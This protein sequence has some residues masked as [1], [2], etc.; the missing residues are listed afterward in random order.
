MR[1]I[2]GE[3]TNVPV[4]CVQESPPLWHRRKHAKQHHNDATRL[5]RMTV[6][7]QNIMVGMLFSKPSAKAY[8]TRLRATASFWQLTWT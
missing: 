6:T 4:E 8:T 5:K 3:T 2:F 7:L 1:F